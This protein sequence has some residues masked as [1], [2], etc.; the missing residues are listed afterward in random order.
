MVEFRICKDWITTR[1]EGN[2]V[3]VEIFGA[4]PSV[5]NAIGENFKCETDISNMGRKQILQYLKNNY[6]TGDFIDMVANWRY[7]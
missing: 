6:D 3:V 4:P 5:I 7:N 2:D 1:E